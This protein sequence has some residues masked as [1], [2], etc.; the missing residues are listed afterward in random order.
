MK[1]R[2]VFAGAAMLVLSTS[3]ASAQVRQ[4]P[5]I[6]LSQAAM[7]SLIA[8]KPRSK[9]PLTGRIRM[10]RGSGVTAMPAGNTAPTSVREV[11]RSTGKK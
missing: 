10:V 7:K 1:A 2:I 4:P 11:K 9:A 8:R 6:V 3:L 5:K